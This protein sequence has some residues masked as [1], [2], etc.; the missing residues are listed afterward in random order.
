MKILI[1]APPKTGKSTLLQKLLEILPKNETG[2]FIA[3]EIL[4][5]K[6]NR[7]GFKSTD[8]TSNTEYVISHVSEVQSDTYVSKYA[9]DIEAIN[10]SISEALTTD[11]SVLIIDEIGRMQ[12][13]SDLFLETVCGLFSGPRCNYFL[14]AS[15]AYDDEPFTHQFKSNEEAITLELSVENR[16]LMPNLIAELYK[17]LDYYRKLSTSQRVCFNRKLEEYVRKNS[18]TRAMKLFSKI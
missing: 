16:E 8:L 1:T 14:I 12:A 6:G 2:G 11:K 10:K 13:N 4:D 3:K 9:V 17:N 7:L 15:I 18:M 5:K